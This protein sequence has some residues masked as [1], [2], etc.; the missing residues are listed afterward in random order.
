MADSLEGH[1]ATH[2]DERE[3]SF[4]DS[5]YSSESDSGLEGVLHGDEG[6]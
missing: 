1:V 6:M 3:M 4:V 5:G 2:C